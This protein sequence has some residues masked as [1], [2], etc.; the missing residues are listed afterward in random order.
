L[1][2]LR[3]WL[4]AAVAAAA[5]AA[6]AA[7]NAPASRRVDVLLGLLLDQRLIDSPPHRV[8]LLRVVDSGNLLTQFGAP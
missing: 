7:A 4:P 6:A 2:V 1:W 3:A 5:A 8:L